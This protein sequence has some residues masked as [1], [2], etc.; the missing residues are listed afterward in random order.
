MWKTL[1]DR[2]RRAIRPLRRLGRSRPVYLLDDV[3]YGYLNRKT[4][5]LFAGFAINGNDTVVDV[6]C[7]AGAASEFAAQCGA[8][9]YAVDIDPAAIASVQHRLKGLKLSRPLHTVVSDSNP[10]PL[11]DGVATRVLAQEVLEH[12]DDPQQFMAELV[13]VGRPGARYLLSVPAA[14]AESVHKVLAPAPYWRKPNHLRV[15]EGDSFDCLVQDAGLVIEKRINY[16]FYW[17]MWWILFWSDRGGFDLGAPGTPVLK[18]WNNTWEALLRTPNGP[19]VKKALDDF[20][21]KSRVLIA[22][23]AA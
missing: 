22:R 2:I 6:G 15:F 3:A 13:R 16:S 9:V 5:E 12:V 4:G 14:G 11:A 21:P 20:M 7:G 1:L 8:A 18:H 19:R 10:L 17:A 23:K